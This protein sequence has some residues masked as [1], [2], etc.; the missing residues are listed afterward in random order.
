MRDLRPVSAFV[1]GA[2]MMAGSFLTIRHYFEVN[3]PA[4]IYEGSFCD[5]ST[6]FN[7]GSSANSEMSAVL[8]VPIGTFGLMLG[9]LFVLAA[10]FDS[11]RLV[12]TLRFLAV[13]NVV[14]VVA[15]LVYSV[16]VL[17]SLCLLCA[18]YYVFSFLALWAVWKG[19]PGIARFA[20]NPLVLVV[21]GIATL[22]VAFGMAEYHGARVQARSGGDAAHVAA[23]FRSLPVLNPPSY[24]S[25]NWIVRST[26]RF[27]D[28]PLRIVAW[29]DFLC[30][31]CLYLARQIER[32]KTD[33]AGRMNVVFQ[34]F[35]LDGE[36]ND[37]VEKDKHP[38][39][40]DLSYMAAYAPEQFGEIY[41][42]VFGDQMAAKTEEWRTEFATRLGVTAA[43][44]DSIAKAIVAA[45]VATGLE[46]EKT[47]DRYAAGIRS[48]PTLLINGRL[49]IGTFPDDLLRVMF[50]AA[51]AEA[52]S[53]S[54]RFLEAWQ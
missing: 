17:G 10:L 49:V 9:A 29:E 50:E 34:H 20:P 39:A 1:A 24:L 7:C 4:T 12:R 48:T 35:P 22:G 14:G 5:I 2:G 8:G 40:C 19:P 41:E 18:I 54:T 42:A 3:F 27:E 16:F 44:E 45:S 26:D 11:R 38:G 53:D 36:C 32:M 30:S 23:Q 46:Y 43:L 21:A 37:V 28:A 47:S 51:L 13:A 25:P 52:E 31:D 6:F 33:Y 15:L